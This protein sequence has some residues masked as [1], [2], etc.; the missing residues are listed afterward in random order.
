[1]PTLDLRIL[2]AKAHADSTHSIR[3]SIAHNGQTRY[4]VTQTIVE[5][6]TE[7][8][9]GTVIK[10][11]DAAFKNTQLRKFLS[12]IEDIISQIN[13][14]EGMTCAELISV[15]KEKLRTDGKPQFPTIQ[16]VFDEYISTARLAPRSVTLSKECFKSLDKFLQT[17][18]CL[19]DISNVSYS[20]IMKYEKFLRDA[21]N[22]D[23]TIRTKMTLFSKILVYARRCGYI[24][25]DFRPFE[26]Y[27][28]PEPVVRESWL[29]TE[30]IKTLRDAKLKGRMQNTT[31][32]FIMLSYC[33]GGIN[34]ADLLKINFSTIRDRNR[35]RYVRTKTSRQRKINKYVE[36]DIPDEAWIY[37]DRLMHSDG[38]LATKYQRG[39]NLHDY[40]AQSM[41]SLRQ[42]T[43]IDNLVYYS[44]RKSF[45]QH[46]FSLGISTGVIDY[47]LGHKLDKGGTSL[48]S[49]ISVTPDMATAAIRNV[50]DNLK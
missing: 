41:K 24:P 34:I 9:N 25:S 26:G 2:P 12:K 39:S 37:I 40:F 15:I 38:F 22:G 14:I 13:Y 44:A 32:D 11:P 6:L 23:S 18:T 17:G 43:N 27:S 4:I 45:A 47:I 10:R 36:F 30:Q 20:T 35:L 50:L 42:Q 7:F 33:L 1:M 48:Y 28:Y 31:R 16:S 46:A 5:K 21:G 29:T 19:S 49:Y 8:K 3:L